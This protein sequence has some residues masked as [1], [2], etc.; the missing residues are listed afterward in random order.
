V[1]GECDGEALPVYGADYGL[2]DICD[3]ADSELGLSFAMRV[4]SVSTVY[5]CGKKTVFP[6]LGY[7]SRYFDRLR[8]A[9]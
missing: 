5:E 6:T 3:A 9:E 1:Y 8:Y 2:G 4:T 7:E